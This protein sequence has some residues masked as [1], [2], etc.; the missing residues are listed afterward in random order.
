MF[1]QVLGCLWPIYDLIAIADAVASGL[2]ARSFVPEIGWSK[3]RLIATQAGTKQ[4]ALKAL[5]FARKGRRSAH[6]R[7][8]IQ[9]SMHSRALRMQNQ[10]LFFRC[11]RLQIDGPGAG[12]GR[13]AAT[14][15]G[16]DP[17]SRPLTTLS[18]M[19]GSGLLSPMQLLEQRLGFL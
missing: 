2:L 4:Q 15:A 10:P 19:S 3:S 5:T 1:L 17:D 16:P 9:L 14:K 12:L 13:C 6:H 18:D 7:R 8:P 11:N